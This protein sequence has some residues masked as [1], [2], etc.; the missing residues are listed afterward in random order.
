MPDNRHK[1]TPAKTGKRATPAPAPAPTP[2]RRTS[3]D[4][5]SVSPVALIGVI[6]AAV[7]HPAAAGAYGDGAFQRVD[8]PQ[9][10]RQG[11]GTGVFLG[12]SGRGMRVTCGEG[13]V[14]EILEVQPAGKKRISGRDFVNGARIHPG[15]RIFGA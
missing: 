1:K 12:A 3:T 15:Q 7:G 9:Y 10:F 11:Q 2:A 14:L 6:A 5:R 4:V 13:S 8:Q